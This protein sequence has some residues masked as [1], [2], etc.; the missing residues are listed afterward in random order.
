MKYFLFTLLYCTNKY[1][2]H[3]TVQSGLISFEMKIYFLKQGKKIHLYHSVFGAVTSLTLHID[4]K[5]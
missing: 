5:I 1:S 2:K 4:A 3:D